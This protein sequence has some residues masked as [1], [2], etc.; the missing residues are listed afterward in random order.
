MWS[1]LFTSCWPS[2]WLCLWEANGG[3]L[4]IVIMGLWDTAVV[5]NLGRLLSRLD[6]HCVTQST[7]PAKALKTGRKYHSFTNCPKFKWLLKVIV[8][9]GPPVN[10]KKSYISPPCVENTKC[11]CG[12]RPC[13]LV[14]PHVALSSY[15][16]EIGQNQNQD[17]QP[18]WLSS[19]EQFYLSASSGLGLQCSREKTG[20]LRRTSGLPGFQHQQQPNPQ[21]FWCGWRGQHRSLF[22][23]Y[24][25]RGPAGPGELGIP[26]WLSLW[27]L[28]LLWQSG[29]RASWGR[30]RA[31]T[32]WVDTLPHAPALVLWGPSS[33]P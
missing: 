29:L 31:L 8:K 17:G 12:A 21:C 23:G 32:S 16:A 5:G 11:S 26:Q 9:W 1:P 18:P 4:Q 28:I 19:I 7:E 20:V 13:P 33:C 22:Q 30:T 24:G 25:S 3:K 14:T 6:H 15:K 10:E 27:Q 2:H